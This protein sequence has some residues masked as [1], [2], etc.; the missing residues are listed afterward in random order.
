MCA[1][2]HSKC[3]QIGAVPF[4]RECLNDK[5]VRHEICLVNGEAVD[6]LDP[7]TTYYI[8]LEAEN[9]ADVAFLNSLGSPT[10]V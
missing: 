10:C 6:V 9:K 8:R 2:M 5:H 3:Q 4:T 7:M 1:R